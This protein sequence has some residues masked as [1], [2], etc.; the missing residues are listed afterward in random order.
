MEDVINDIYTVCICNEV[1]YKEVMDAI[2][3]GA[4]TVE[5][6]MEKTSAGTGCGLCKSS[7]DDVAGERAIHLD[8]ILEKAKLEGLCQEDS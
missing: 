8:E 7:K 3:E 4:C 5:E 1:T 6:I 2:K